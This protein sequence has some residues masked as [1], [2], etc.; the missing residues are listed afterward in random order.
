MIASRT[1]VLGLQRITF[2][3]DDVAESAAFYEEKVRFAPRGTVAG[4]A[5]FGFG[6]SGSQL[7]LEQSAQRGMKVLAF[8]VADADLDA[9]VAHAAAAGVPVVIPPVTA[10]AAG[11]KRFARLRDPDGNLVDLV[12]S[13]T[14]SDA[15]AAAPTVAKK[16][17]HVVLWTPDIAKMEAFLELLGM[18]VSDRTHLGMSFLRCNTEHHT[19]GLAQSASG[20]TGMQHAAFDVGTE[21]I[22]D[23]ES[24]RLTESGV[25]CIWGPGRHGPGN[26]IFSYYLDP[27]KNIFEL[28]GDMERVPATDA[29]LVPRYWGTEHRGDI[30]GKAGPPP[31]E[32]RS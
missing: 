7:Y 11:E 6:A 28:Y 4:R 10:E 3:V 21:R 17:G 26:N 5:L 14:G 27:S 23:E 13:A 8:A 29:E 31:A 24:A 2:G 1:S 22:V 30:S 32:F 12:V 16:L 19:I 20:R 9:L 18:R 25:R 15:G